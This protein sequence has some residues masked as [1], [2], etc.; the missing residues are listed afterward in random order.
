MT[1]QQSLKAEEHD[2]ATEQ[3]YNSIVCVC[4]CLWE[5]GGWL[6]SQEDHYCKAQN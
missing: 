6:L 1:V 3:M 5:G 4:M 2:E